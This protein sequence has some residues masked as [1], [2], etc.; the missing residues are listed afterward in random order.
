M[1]KE[2]EKTTREQPNISQHFLWFC[3]WKSVHFRKKTDWNLEIWLND[4]DA[5]PYKLTLSIDIHMC[6]G[7]KHLAIARAFYY[8]FCEIEC[9]S[10]NN[11]GIS[12]T[13]FVSGRYING[14]TH[15]KKSAAAPSTAAKTVLINKQA[16]LK[17][18]CLRIIM[19]R[20][21]GMSK[22]LI[23]FVFFFDHL[24]GSW[25]RWKTFPLTFFL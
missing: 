5:N 6:I 24:W 10:F 14:Q 23:F 8:L 12:Y 11:K 7:W 25:W 16:R 20:H 4:S 1:K 13:T 19:S 22:L 2:R 17:Q 21:E 15:S 3:V 18:Y 9:G